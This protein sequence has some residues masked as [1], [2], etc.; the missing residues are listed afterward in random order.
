[1]YI[2][3]YAYTYMCVYM[4]IYIYIHLFIYS[5]F[6]HGPVF[7]HYLYGQGEASEGVKTIERVWILVPL[8]A[9]PPSEVVKTIQLVWNQCSGSQ[10][11]LNSER[12]SNQVYSSESQ[13]EKT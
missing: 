9:S 12:V 4:Y 3:T 5:M 13:C 11:V 7:K 2:Y 10:K 1:M 8:Q 6:K